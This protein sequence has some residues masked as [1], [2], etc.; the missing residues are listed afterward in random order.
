[1][2]YSITDPNDPFS[3]QRFVQA[4]QADYNIAVQELKA[5]H[6]E[7]HWMWYIFPQILGLGK[8]QSAFRFAIRNKEEAVAYLKHPTLGKR[9]EECSNIVLN[10]QKTKITDVFDHTDHLKFKSC[11][12]LFS[13]VS[14]GG[15]VFQKIL[16]KYY[17]GHSDPQTL[18]F[19]NE[20]KT[21]P[22]TPPNEQKANKLRDP[23]FYVKNYENGWRVFLPASSLDQFLNIIKRAI[24]KDRFQLEQDLRV[25]TL[26]LK[27]SEF[28]WEDFK[29]R[30]STEGHIQELAHY[31]AL[32]YKLVIPALY[33]A[34]VQSRARKIRQYDA[35]LVEAQL[36]E[37]RFL[38][39]RFPFMKSLYGSS[40]IKELELMTSCL[41]GTGR[42]SKELADHNHQWAEGKL[43][44][45]L[46]ES[47]DR[48]IPYVHACW[49]DF[50]QKAASYFNEEV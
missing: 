43:L 14:E 13:A 25:I 12:T 46:Q 24:K 42:V 27:K 10:L 47:Y 4:Q 9:L 40:E 32:G 18:E 48:I 7:T 38:V 29:E 15:S 5:G 49:F 1:M 19:L 8:S 28:P 45:N 31:E 37:E 35:T 39:K 2:T 11:M 50:A 30:A 20:V 3:L 41:Q 23:E 16:T 34:F 36:V 44:E 33:S 26:K 6:K 22:E 21:A 17:H